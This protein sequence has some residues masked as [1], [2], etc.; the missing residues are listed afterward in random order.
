MRSGRCRSAAAAVFDV[1]DS[2]DGVEFVLR[3]EAEQTRETA[4]LMVCLMEQRY[5]DGTPFL[6]G[7]HPKG[8]GCARATFTVN[9][10]LPEELRPGVIADPGARYDA[11]VRFSNA[12]A[13]MR[14]D[15]PPT[16]RASPGGN[17][18]NIKAPRTPAPPNTQRPNVLAVALGAA[19]V[20]GEHV[21]GAALGHVWYRFTEQPRDRLSH[22]ARIGAPAGEHRDVL[23]AVNFER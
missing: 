15:V 5:R 17:T 20:D 6:R 1:L 16:R 19:L 3:G 12:A 2:I 8:H 18:G 11:V 4:E 10:N 14:P 9:A 22:A 21:D 7:V 23:L 13:V